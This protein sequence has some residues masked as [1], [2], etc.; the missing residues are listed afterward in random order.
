MIMFRVFIFL[1]LTVFITVIIKNII[2]NIVVI[3]ISFKI[4]MFY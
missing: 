4:N 3:R 1:D 2:K